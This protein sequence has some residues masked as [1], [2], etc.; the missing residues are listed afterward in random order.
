MVVEDGGVVAV[1]QHERELD[2]A[3]P[4]LGDAVRFEAVLEVNGALIEDVVAV[5][6]EEDSPAPEV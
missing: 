5:W 2:T 3:A 4:V 6:E 1:P